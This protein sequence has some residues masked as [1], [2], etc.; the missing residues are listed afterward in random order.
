[1]VQQQEGV[2]VRVPGTGPP[3]VEKSDT[4]ASEKTS[5]TC[6]ILQYSFVGDTVTVTWVPVPVQSCIYIYISLNIAK[7][8]SPFV[9]FRDV[10]KAV[11]HGALGQAWCCDKYHIACEATHGH[12][13]QSAVGTHA[14]S[15]NPFDCS[16]LLSSALISRAL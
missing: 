16:V 3:D 9:A 10:P 15:G 13:A 6:R 11:D 7:R 8:S 4:N 14:K 1:M 2:A 12:H 5:T